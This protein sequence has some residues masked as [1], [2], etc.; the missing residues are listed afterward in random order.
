VKHPA[1]ETHSLVEASP[2]GFREAL[3][4]CLVRRVVLV[5][6]PTISRSIDFC[7]RAAICT[8]V[9]REGGFTTLKQIWAAS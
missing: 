4:R 6:G 5:G 3:E 1:P 8:W 2:A 9:V 7:T